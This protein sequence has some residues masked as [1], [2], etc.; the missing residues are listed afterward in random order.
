MVFRILLILNTAIYLRLCIGSHTSL[1]SLSAYLWLQYIS[2][3][4]II[5]CVYQFLPALPG[6]DTPKRII[7][8]SCLSLYVRLLMTI[9]KKYN[10]PLYQ[11]Q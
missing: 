4:T 3:A 9:E 7:V 1:Y 8:L 2:H 11:A 6:T 10:L 5:H